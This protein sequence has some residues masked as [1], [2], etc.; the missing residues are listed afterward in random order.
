[1]DVSASFKKRT[2]LV[3]ML[4]VSTAGIFVGNHYPTEST[5]RDIITFFSGEWSVEKNTFSFVAEKQY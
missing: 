4:I 2:A 1:M 5:D 3:Q